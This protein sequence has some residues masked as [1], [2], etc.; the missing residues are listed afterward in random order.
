MSTTALSSVNKVLTRLRES[1]VTSSTFPSNIY[2]QLILQF[3]N[4][5]KQEIE[6]A[7]DWTILRQT[8][9]ITTVI[10]T[11][12]YSI[13]GAGQRFRFY[14]KRQIII[15]ETTKDLIVLGNSGWMEE[16]KRTAVTGNQHPTWYRF[17]GQDASGDPIIEVYPAPDA[18]YALKVPL[19]VPQADLSLFSDTYNIPS[20]VVEMGTW[21]RAISE[22]GE[23]GGQNT[24]EQ[25]QLYRSFLADNIAQDAGRVPDETI[26]EVV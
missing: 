6:N 25:W 9:S 18:V 19:V 4:E 17:V 14:D 26:W 3:V 13:T 24:S 7:W 10:G 23:D 8:L 16:A 12:T 22:R 2:A 5:T 11:N 20:L 15:N 1:A 21:A